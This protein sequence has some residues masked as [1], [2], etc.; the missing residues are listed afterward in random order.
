MATS[1][2][3]VPLLA[4]Q[5]A[6]L[7]PAMQYIRG[8][9]SSSCASLTRADQ[10]CHSEISLGEVVMTVLALLALTQPPAP[11]PPAGINA[12]AALSLS[13]T[14]DLVYDERL[15][16][17]FALGTLAPVAGD[18]LDMFG[19]RFSSQPASSGA[20]RDRRRFVNEASSRSPL[21]GVHRICSRLSHA[22]GAH[23]I[24]PLGLEH[25]TNAATPDATQV[26]LCYPWASVALV[27]ATS[28]RIFPS[29]GAS[30]ASCPHRP[31]GDWNAECQIA[32]PGFRESEAGDAVAAA[33]TNPGCRLGVGSFLANRLWAVKQ[34]PALSMR[35]AP[36]QA[37]KHHV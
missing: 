28:P 1:V 3:R 25:C 27:A 17:Y 19:S 14:L 24:V 18:S 12:L 11:H 29:P 9:P 16:R 32:R 4:V 22:G 20:P 6:S 7:S 2:A 13:A 8:R 35:L 36:S 34:M 23:I 33:P 31:C 30:N 15:L 10:T 26:A 21:A 5:S 37:P